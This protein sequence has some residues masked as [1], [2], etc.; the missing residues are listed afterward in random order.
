M[1]RGLHH[2]FEKKFQCDLRCKVTQLYQTSPQSA[3]IISLD[4]NP[5]KKDSRQFNQM[6]CKLKSSDLF[7]NTH[8]THPTTHTKVN[9]L[10]QSYGNAILLSNINCI[11]HFKGVKLDHLALFIDISSWLFHLII[12]QTPKHCFY[13]TKYMV[14]KKLPS[15]N[16][17]YSLTSLPQTP[18]LWT[19]S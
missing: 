1:L 17:Y 16:N 4:Q 5:H 8:P 19:L 12:P 15:K 9:C 14:S 13:W 2:I 3:I 10:N 11:N 18:W 6:M 7:Y